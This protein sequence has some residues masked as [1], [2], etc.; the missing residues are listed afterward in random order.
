MKGAGAAGAAGA[1]AAKYCCP[2]VS[3][4]EES[5]HIFNLYEL[6]TERG[7]ADV[8]LFIMTFLLPPPSIKIELL[9][10]PENSVEFETFAVDVPNIRSDIIDFGAIDCLNWLLGLG[11]NDSWQIEELR[12]ILVHSSR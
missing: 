7:G 2:A 5:G 9:L 10:L 1:A 12:A 3:L 4:L 6:D 11:C 8:G